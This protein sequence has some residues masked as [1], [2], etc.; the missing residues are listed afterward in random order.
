MKTLAASLLTFSILAVI[1]TIAQSA[2][3]PDMKP[4]TMIG[5]LK[6]GQQV[7]LVTGTAGGGISGFNIELPN[8]RYIKNFEKSNGNRK[9]VTSKITEIGSDFIV[10][11]SANGT[12]KTIALH[13]IDVITKLPELKAE[14][15]DESR[16]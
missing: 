5:R 10:V 2:S 9:Y 11:T 12:E 13:A 6:V 14:A 16:K 7:R 8:D 3:E 15:D 4:A 1:C